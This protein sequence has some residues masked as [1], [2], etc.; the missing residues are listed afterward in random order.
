M[1][2]NGEHDSRRVKYARIPRGSRSYPGG[3]PFCQM[4]ASRGFV[5]LSK[6]SA[7]AVDPNHY[8]DDCQC[9][10]VPSWGRGSVEG[11]D[12]HAYDAGYQEWLDQEVST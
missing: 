4:L 2:S 1:Y 3:C 5:Y 6:L 11:Y 12:R 7:G 10:V 8:H 9:M